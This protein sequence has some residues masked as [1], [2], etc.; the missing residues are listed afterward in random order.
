MSAAPAERRMPSR[1]QAARL[2]AVQALYQWQEGEHA[3]AEIIEQFLSVRMSELGEGGMR[4]DADRPLFKD[5]VEGSVSHREELEQTVSTALA[6]GWTWPRIDRLVRAILLAGAYELLHRHDVPA[7]V[8][9]NEYVEIAHAFYGQGEFELREF[10]AR[11]RRPRDP[12]LRIRK[13]DDMRRG[14]RIGEFE[15]IA[16]Y[17]APLARDFPGAGGLKSD[18]A[19]LP[20]D[21]RHDLVVKTDTVVAGV[22]FVADESP[23]RI[24]AKALRVCL[25]DLA[26]GGAMPYTYQLSLSLPQDWTERWVAAFARGLA[27]DQRRYGIVLCGGDTVQA[28][29]PLTVTIT[30]FGRVPHGRGLTRAGA[31]AGD[32][33]WVSG[34]IGDAA[35]GLLA[36]RGEID[37]SFLEGRYRKP[38]PRTSLG[39]RLLGVATATADVSDGL[40]ADAGHIGEASRLSVAIERDRI[41]LSRAARR[42][43]DARPALWRPVL[44]GGDDYELVIA[45]PPPKSPA[46]QRV[47]RA[48]G[49]AVTEIGRFERGRGVR[50]AVDGR[51]VA[52]RRLG[53]VHF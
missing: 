25:S 33:L 32:L 41:P 21:A 28:P 1:R 22:H 29:G 19:F 52:A 8:A 34:T 24:A 3:P 49:V 30:A 53:Y 17:F 12:R 20:A 47:A 37:S 2:A 16:R 50:L 45:V 35:L 7:K 36:A 5:V 38:Q 44:S 9:I 27:A 14:E 42:I 26:A 13:I 4:R 48:A 18:N 46:L 10:G 23:G 31:R 43:L 6:E 39:P 11:P 51:P 15:L 40:L